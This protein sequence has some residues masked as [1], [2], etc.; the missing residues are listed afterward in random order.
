[1]KIAYNH[2][3]S[4]I[5]SK[6]DINELS[7][8]LFQLGHEHEIENNI[9]N[10]EFTPNRGDCLSINGILRDLAVFYEVTPNQE[11]YEH[12]L[13][14]L[15]LDFVNNASDACHQISFLKIEIE[16]ETLPYEGALNNY[17]ND[18]QL[19]KNN[20]F[21][22]ISNYISYETGQPTHC[23]DFNKIKGGISLKH[24]NNDQ[25]FETLLDKTINL[26]GSNLVFFDDEGVINLAG[27]VGSKSTACNA[28][29]RSVLVECAYFNPEAIIGKSIKYSIQSEAAHKFERNID[30]KTQKNTLKRFLRIVDEHSKIKNVQ[31]FSRTYTDFNETRIPLNIK[32]IKQILGLDITDKACLDI[33]KRLNFHIVDSHVLVPS[34]RSDVKT[35]NDLAEEIARVVGYNN[36]KPKKIQI[37]KKLNSVK[38]DIEPPLRDFLINNGFYEVINNPFTPIN[39]P[40][41]IRVDNPLD[42][43]RGFLRTEL[44]Q[45]LI[46]NLLYNERR[47]KDSIKLFEISDVYFLESEVIKKRVLGV[48]ASGRV[49]KNYIDFS[50]KISQEYLS[51]I[52]N[53]QGMSNE[54]KFQVI[55]RQELNTKIKTP[56]IYTEID[57]DQFPND[58]IG[59]KGSSKSKG[60]TNFVLYEN[61]SEFPSSVRDLSFST[62]NHDAVGDLEKL[63]ES[64][65]NEIIK[66]KF[67]FDFFENPK[68][69][70]I[71]IGYRFIFQSKLGTL[72][73]FEIDD[74]INDIISNA[75]DIDGLSLPGFINK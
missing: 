74:I 69:K 65:N 1:M 60:S 52:F 59:F 50:K 41:S 58:F 24:I 19:N 2:L 18:L 72:K 40:N 34:Y 9:F 26:T 63:I 33:F 23:Y 39:K 21:T 4:H 36:I 28:K 73:D 49:G 70:E 31:Y 48:I 12:D 13:K 54:L 20:F 3:V 75:L 11:M 7:D 66:E 61:I 57:L 35:Q 32:K 56:I 22:D 47:Q 71:K 10:I 14:K 30:P 64:F 46:N 25:A 42:S 5:K 8:Y 51:N 16:D 45:S 67:I 62:K 6:P 68:S 43:N 38:K 53:H 15:D 37:P 55:S 29:T 44:K 27:V 17:F